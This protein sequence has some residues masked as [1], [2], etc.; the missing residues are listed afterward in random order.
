MPLLSPNQS[1]Q[2]KN[3]TLPEIE[4]AEHTNQTDEKNR[5]KMRSSRDRDDQSDRR[6][7]RDKKRSREK[8]RYLEKPDRYGGDRKRSP[9][10]MKSVKELF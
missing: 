1:H 4:N 5:S 10:I 8:D 2:I 3:G 7:D 9:E 6:D